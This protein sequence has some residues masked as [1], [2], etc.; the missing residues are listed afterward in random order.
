MY[1]RSGGFKLIRIG[2]Q[3]GRKAITAPGDAETIQS[4]VVRA[5]QRGLAA[6]G[7]YDGAIDGL[8]GPRTNVA[9]AALLRDRADV[10]QGD[11]AGW[12]LRRCAVGA[13]Q[14]GCLEAGFDVGPIDGLWGPRT[15][16]AVDLLLEFQETGEM[17]YLWREDVPRDLNPHGW[18]REAELEAGYGPPCQVA[19]TPVRVPWTL[20]LAWQP[21]TR[22]SEIGCHPAV[23]GSLATVLERVHAHYGEREIGRLGLD[24]YG[25]CYNCR[26]KRAGRSWSTHAWGVA[27]D[28]DPDRNR[29]RWGR[30]KAALAHRDFC[31]WWRFW[32]E[33]GWVSLGRSRGFDW[34]HVQAAKL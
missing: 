23:A 6:S 13:V 16:T 19:L 24:L 12:S 31:D 18:P 14:I 25:G 33:E 2:C 29:L 22:V 20:K 1:N 21:R 30:D 28:W 17:P 8:R 9:V 7:H 27:I 3:A 32:E 4:G 15:D 11:T 26:P 5:L 34:M 10:I